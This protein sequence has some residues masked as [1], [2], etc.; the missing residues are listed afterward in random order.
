MSKDT[1]T[2]KKCVDLNIHADNNLKSTTQI[3]INT[4]ILN[5]LIA[6]YINNKY[7]PNTYVTTIRSHYG[8]LDVMKYQMEK[9]G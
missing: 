4:H 9:N 8:S 1:K 5:T 7:Y 2:R 3:P 6:I